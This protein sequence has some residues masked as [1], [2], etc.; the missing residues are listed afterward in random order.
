METADEEIERLE[1]ELLYLLSRPS[2]ARD[3]KYERR[4]GNVLAIRMRLQALG[5]DVMPE[6]GGLL[7]GDHDRRC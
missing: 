6:L 5:G 3:L 1:G 2:T 7:P 4:E